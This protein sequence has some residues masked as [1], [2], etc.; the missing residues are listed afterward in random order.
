[1]E[2]VEATKAWLITHMVAAM[3]DMVQG[4]VPIEVDPKVGQSWAGSEERS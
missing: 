3:D 2:Q 1:V 4:G